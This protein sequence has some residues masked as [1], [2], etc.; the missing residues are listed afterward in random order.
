VLD[1]D[2]FDDLFPGYRRAWC[3]FL[4]RDPD[5]VFFSLDA[6]DGTLLFDYEQSPCGGR[7][8]V[9]VAMERRRARRI[10][11]DS[12]GV[13]TRERSGVRARLRPHGAR[14]RLY[15]HGAHL[16]DYNRLDRGE[17]IA[18]AWCWL[19]TWGALAGR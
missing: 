5:R 18:L 10:L 12:L 13:R 6:P 19:R 4:S 9:P 15:L 17:R 3:E 16:I 1:W 14:V 2:S 8:G 7:T 11:G